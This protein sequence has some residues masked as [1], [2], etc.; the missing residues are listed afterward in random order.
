MSK[1]T[2]VVL[3]LLAATGT[4]VLALDA[5]ERAGARNQR[6][7]DEMNQQ[8][9]SDALATCNERRDR[10]LADYAEA[11]AACAQNLE[12]SRARWMQRLKDVAV[13]ADRCIDALHRYCR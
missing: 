2:C 11:N 10:L 9:V 8:L 6:E 13:L 7:V 5:G 1:F 4:G 12:E 3:V